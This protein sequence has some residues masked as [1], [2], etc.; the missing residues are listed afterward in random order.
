MRFLT[1]YARTV[2]E[3]PLKFYELRE[4]RKRFEHKEY[5]EGF[6]SVPLGVIS[7]FV[8]ES[9]DNMMTRFGY[10]ADLWIDRHF[11]FVRPFYRHIV[12]VGQPK[13]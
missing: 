5:Y 3:K 11:P 10:K 4:F 6:L 13:V 7:K 2:D 1:P 8:F 9:P 12:I